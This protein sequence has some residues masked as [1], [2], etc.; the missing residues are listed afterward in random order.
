[1]IK[2]T[3]LELHQLLCLESHEG[4]LLTM[5]ETQK[6]EADMTLATRTDTI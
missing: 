3:R 4:V 6:V 2:F 1:M 5:N